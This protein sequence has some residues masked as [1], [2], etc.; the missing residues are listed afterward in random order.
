MSWCYGDW[1]RILIHG[2]SSSL[3]CSEQTL[4]AFHYNQCVVIW[5]EFIFG[6]ITKNPILPQTLTM[7]PFKS[8]VSA[9]RSGFARNRLGKE[10][11]LQI[12]NG[13]RNKQAENGLSR[14]YT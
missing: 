2:I 10:A 1:S 13:K 4:S 11:L 7:F 9:Y 5:R 12:E 3:L 6:Y 8:S 14:R